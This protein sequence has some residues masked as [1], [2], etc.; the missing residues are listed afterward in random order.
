MKRFSKVSL[1]AVLAVVMSFG[2][3]GVASAVT[4]P[5]L[6]VANSFVIL[7]ST[8]TNTAGGTTLNGNVGYTTPPAVAPTINGTVY[9]PLTPDTTTYN[10]AG[11]DQGVALADLQNQVATFTFAPGPIDLASDT[12]HGTIG[13]Y[14]PGKYAITGAA[15]IGGGGTITLRG[16]GT[17]IFQMDGA[18]NTSANS[19]VRYEEGASPC[20]V[21]WIPTA[22]TTLG[23]NST[24]LGTVIDDSGITIGS[25]VTWLGRALAFGGTVS[26]DTDTITE[27]AC[28]LNPDNS[29]VA[30]YTGGNPQT[31]ANGNILILGGVGALVLLLA[32]SGA[33]KV[34]QRNK[35]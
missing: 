14:T 2:L 25:N 5:T 4:T 6:G 24:F 12:T 15:D 21:F 23:A 3:I 11:I 16:K 31:S 17:Y 27:A 34:A 29:T 9:T 28:P 32:V 8:Y 10:Q 18:L 20:N 33:F 35:I 13:I 7:S 19:I 26:T 22:A 1:A 30:P